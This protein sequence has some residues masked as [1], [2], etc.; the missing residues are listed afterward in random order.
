[1]ERV[2][3][4]DVQEVVI[5][6]KDRLCRY[7]FELVEFFFKKT[8]TK[9]VVLGQSVEEHDATRELADDLLAICNYFV[10]KNNGMRSSEN[11][12]KRKQQQKEG[13]AEEEASNEETKNSDEECEER[14]KKKNKASCRQGEKD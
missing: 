4:G 3:N 9:L 6:H 7:G 1:L 14:F 5:T 8:S 10:A 11:R 13:K 12:R 2:Y